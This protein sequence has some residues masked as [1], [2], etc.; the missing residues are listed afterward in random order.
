M[1]APERLPELPVDQTRSAVSGRRWDG[2]DVPAGASPIERVNAALPNLE[3]AVKAAKGQ[4]EAQD[5][6]AVPF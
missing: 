2:K 4:A 6:E 5:P 1:N 3:F